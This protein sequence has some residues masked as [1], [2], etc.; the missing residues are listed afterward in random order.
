MLE[1]GHRC[2]VSIRFPRPTKRPRRSEPEVTPGVLRMMVDSQQTLRVVF[3]AEPEE[4][5]GNFGTLEQL[6][7]AFHLLV[8]VQGKLSLLDF[9]P[10]G[11]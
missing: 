10:H 4:G 1:A 8:G 9:F 7:I 3:L 11:A 6:D 5:L 2:W